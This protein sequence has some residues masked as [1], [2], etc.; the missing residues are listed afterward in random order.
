[1][2][3]RGLVEREVGRDLDLGARFGGFLDYLKAFDVSL[4]GRAVRFVRG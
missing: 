2:L 4:L 3:S 1:M